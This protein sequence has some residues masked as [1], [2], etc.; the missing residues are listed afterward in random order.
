MKKGQPSSAITPA[1]TALSSFHYSSIRLLSLSCPFYSELSYY[2]EE[3]GNFP[4]LKHF[5]LVGKPP[6]SFNSRY[7]RK[8]SGSLSL[9]LSSLLAQA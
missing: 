5:T 7:Y 4:S 8:F 1:K 6:P 2:Y 3:L 9:R